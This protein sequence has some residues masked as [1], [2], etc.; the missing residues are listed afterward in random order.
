MRYAAKI[1][2]TGKNYFGWQRQNNHSEREI[3]VQQVIEEALSNLNHQ[4]LVKITGA[5]RTDQGVHAKGQVASFELDKKFEPEKL[6]LAA[7]FY[8]P[9]D[10]RIMQIFNVPYNFDARRSAL[11]R[12]YKYFIWHGRVCPPHLN[13]FVWWRKHDW[14]RDLARQACKLIVGKHDFRAFCKAVECPDNTLRDIYNL[15][16]QKWGDLSV[17]TVRAPSFLTNMVRIIAGNIDAVAIKKNNLDWLENLLK[18]DERI[19]SAMTAPACG[20][21]FWRAGYNEIKI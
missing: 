9:D 12:E 11:W 8:L 2:Y 14:D 6:R 3:G 19:H 16:F 18:G 17:L 1:A 7:N 20:L 21:W 4:K 10:I 15:K 5:G 13:G